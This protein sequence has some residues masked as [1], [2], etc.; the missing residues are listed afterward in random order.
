MK[1][2]FT[3]AAAV[4]LFSV[5]A[6]A[7]APQDASLLPGTTIPVTLTKKID[8]AKTHAGDAVTGRTTQRVRLASGETMPKGALLRGHVVEASS[9]HFNPAHYAVQGN[10]VLSIQFD[11][12]TSD[13]HQVPLHVYVRALAA[14]V[15]VAETH[16]PKA[17]DMD[18]LGTTTQ[19]GGDLVTPSQDEILSERGDIV[20]YRHDGGNYAHLIASSGNSTVCDGGNTEQ[21][22][23]VF[24]ASACGAYGFEQE[25]LTE[26]GGNVLT[27]VS[28]HFT[29][30]LYAN[31]ALL[32]EEQA[33]TQAAK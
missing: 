25:S 27:L 32:L 26:N 18:S 6:F 13:G 28:N 30:R 21:A 5:T 4:A 19:V 2:T 20:G 29:P 15:T 31:T 9:F 24:S 8:A 16:M 10:A 17:S 11:S 1:H 23:D 14:P 7:A 22:M 12:I 3:A 33:P